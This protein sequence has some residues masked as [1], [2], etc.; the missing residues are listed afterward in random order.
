MFGCSQLIKSITRSGSLS[1]L[2]GPQSDHRVLFADFNPNSI[3]G[4]T[5]RKQDIGPPIS[6]SL[7]EEYIKA[8]HE[9]YADHK[10]VKRIQKLF[11]RHTK[12]TRSQI[13]K[14]LKKWECDQGRRA[15]AHAKSIVTPRFRKPYSWTQ[16]SETRGSYTNT[17]GCAAGKK[18]F[19]KITQKPTIAKNNR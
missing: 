2:D 17:G 6:R 16:H 14:H 18:I 19:T 5:T 11:D 15:M 1:Y 8:M 13:K 3:L 12:L 7:V 10:M 4:H 9:Y